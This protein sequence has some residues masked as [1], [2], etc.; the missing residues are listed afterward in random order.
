MWQSEDQ[1]FA[2]ITSAQAVDDG[3]DMEMYQREGEQEILNDIE[4]ELEGL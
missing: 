2:Y 1:W 3:W 4:A